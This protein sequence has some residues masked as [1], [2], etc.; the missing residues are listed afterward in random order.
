MARIEPFQA[1]LK[2]GESVTIR[3]GV[4][5]DAVALLHI[6]A[7]NLADGEGQL[8]E[9]GEFAPTEEQERA[10]IRG[11]VENPGEL[12]LVAEKDGEIIGN[13]DCH[14]GTRRRLSHTAV[15]GMSLMP[16]WRG[17]GLGEI[18]L[19]GVIEWAK[20]N[21]LLEKLELHV[22]SSNARAMA[23]YSKLGFK[24][25]GRLIKAVKYSDGRYD[26]DVCMG[27]FV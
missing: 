2:S 24:E 22:L 27:L 15:F 23:L 11:M 14:R 10:W 19:K 8:W 12:L 5:S 13:I 21:P 25:E 7:T 6:L 16:I 4:E 20:A 18:L 1:K 17:Q 9:K 26:D 3:T